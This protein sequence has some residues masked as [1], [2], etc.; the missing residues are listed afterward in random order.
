MLTNSSKQSTNINLD[1]I[2]SI[3]FLD[4]FSYP[5]TGYEIWQ[6]LD[7]D[8]E[9]SRVIDKL[10]DLIKKEV[11]T[12]KEGFYFLKGQEKLI[13][14]R[15]ERYNYTQHKLK[16]AKRF[17]RL[18]SLFPSVR[19]VAVAN[20][21]G[22]YNLRLNSDIDLFIITKPGRIWLTRLFCAGLAKI[23]H[24]RPTEDNKKNKI[25]LSFYITTKALNLKSLE[26]ND[27]DPYFYYWKK[28]LIPLYDYKNIWVNFLAANDLF[29]FDQNKVS[30]LNSLDV[31]ST[32]NSFFDGFEKMAK[33]FQFK[34]MAPE[35]KQ[36]QDNN[37]GVFIS[38]DVLKLYLQDRRLEF[39]NKFNFK[40]HEVSQKI[41]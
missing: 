33:K 32:V 4:I 31:N 14:I 21:I 13:K 40:M 39:F 18:F 5:L 25:C 26:L 3:V 12:F 16:I 15:R 34:I 22:G 17:S 11:L 38:N 41:N 29:I 6:F 8:Y 10:D 9:F 24:S 35:L 27:G 30:V 7:R 19:L 37:T 36:S 28:G 2:K 20:L 23:L 1:I